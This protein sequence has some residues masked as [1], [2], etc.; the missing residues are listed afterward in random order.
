MPMT[1]T[2]PHSPLNLITENYE[3][4]YAYD[5]HPE[6]GDRG[7]C[8]PI[9]N[10]LIAQGWRFDQVHGGDTCDHCGARLR[11]V[12]VL[13]HIPTHTLI[14]VGEICLD[15]RFSLATGE[16]RR[17]RK[18]AALN[19]DRMARH[20]K[21][22]AFLAVEV[23]AR[24]RPAQAGGLMARVTPAMLLAAEDAIERNYPLPMTPAL[25]AAFQAGLEA[26]LDFAEC[27]TPGGCRD[28]LECH[29]GAWVEGKGAAWA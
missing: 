24:S 17:L 2:D 8:V 6:E 20:E 22:H 26:A 28:P 4:A 7:A 27:P 29:C 23:P 10:Q 25:R 11:Y 21:R 14:K 3:Y 16:F 5:G 13:K 9:V 15:N 12:A 18:N 1:R 19:R